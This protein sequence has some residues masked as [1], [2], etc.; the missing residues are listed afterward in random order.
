[1]DDI[2]IYSTTLEEHLFQLLDH[3]QFLIKRSKCSFAQKST[4]YLGHLILGKGVCTEP[5]KVEVV[6]Q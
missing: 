3:H 6:L 2:L 5:S 4:E 1:M